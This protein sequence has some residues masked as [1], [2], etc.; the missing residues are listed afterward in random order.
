MTTSNPSPLPLSRLRSLGRVLAGRRSDWLPGRPRRPD[1][2]PSL[3]WLGPLAV[4]LSIAIGWFAFAGA[5]GEDGSVAFGLFIGSASIVAMAWSFLLALRLPAL[6]P[7]FGG[8]DTAYRFHRRAG[9]FAVVAM[10]L[11]TSVEP[12]IEGGVR[13]A[14]KS[15]ADTAEGLAGTGEI[16]LY[17]LV[18]LSAIRWMPYRWWRWTHKLLGVPFAF[19]CFHFFTAEKPYANS[20]AWGLWFGAVMIVGL[21][22]WVGRVGV[23]DAL[24]RGRRHTVASVRRVGRSTELLLEPSGQL[25]THRLGQ[26]AML[27]FQLPG[28]SEPHPFTIASA[29]GAGELKFVIKDLGDWSARLQ[30]ADLVGAEV[31][32]EGPYGRFDPMGH[33]TDEPPVWIAGGVGVTPFLGAVDALDP[34]EPGRRPL[35]ILCV[36]ERREAIGLAELEAAHADGRIELAVIS[37][38]EGNRFSSAVLADL[39][40]GRRLGGVHVVACGPDG[41]VRAADRAVA[42]LGGG[43]LEVEDFDIRG[44]VGPDLSVEVAEVGESLQRRQRSS[45]GSA[46]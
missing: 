32:V 26:F 31:I 35:L 28:L 29:P 38:A 24:L 39:V 33:C 27:K 10:F 37:S 22:S 1:L 36:R 14:S 3:S 45:A 42:Q 2:R 17:A 8:L 6:E 12:E 40:G 19:A 30:D 41:L 9:V 21:V 20:S 18:V 5:T 44:G 7:L 13:G 16:M 43:P 4:V 46:V 15:L 11:H 23:R 25:M 34:A